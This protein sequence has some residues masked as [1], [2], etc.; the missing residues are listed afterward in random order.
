MI[1]EPGDCKWKNGFPILGDQE[2][3]FAAIAGRF[4][5]PQGQSEDEWL[6]QWRKDHNTHYPQVIDG[7]VARPGE[8]KNRVAAHALL[9]GADMHRV[10]LRGKDMHG[11]NLTNANFRGAD[12]ERANLRGATL[13]KCDFSRSNLR[14]ATFDEADLSGS[15]MSM[16]YMKAASFVGAKMWRVWLRHVM[17]E[18]AQFFNADMRYCDLR[19]S[20]FWGARFD[21]A[22]TEDIANADKASFARWLNVEGNDWSL[23][24]KPGYVKVVRNFT[25]SMSY[26][27]NSARR[28]E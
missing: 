23:D 14:Y 12:L 1:V 10:D 17:A 26:Q 25:G 27:G 8:A 19:Y 7:V 9:V 5:G 4:L 13:I 18:S 20:D 28:P 24:E 6:K 22:N 2:A 3:V 16:A 11:L 15:D 21:G